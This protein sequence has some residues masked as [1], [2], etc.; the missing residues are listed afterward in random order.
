MEDRARVDAGPFPARSLRAA[1]SPP[2][3][4]LQP[5]S[6]SRG[7]AEGGRAL[8]TPVPIPGL[9]TSLP[10]REH[11][12]TRSLSCRS[13]IR[14]CCICGFRVCDCPGRIQKDIRMYRTMDSM[15]KIEIR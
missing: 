3:S 8:C 13:F 6:E 11:G 4:V 12:Q 10:E 5:R 2:L 9:V 1:R 7:P 14:N 15:W